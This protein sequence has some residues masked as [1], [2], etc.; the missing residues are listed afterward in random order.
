MTATRA[1]VLRTLP[2]ELVQS[3]LIEGS[4][5]SGSREARAWELHLMPGERLRIGL[6][7]LEVTELVIR[8]RGY[9]DDEQ[10]EFLERLAQFTRRGGG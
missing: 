9:S 6:L 3:S 8:L 5:V 7:D 1:E 10:L 2:P 4:R